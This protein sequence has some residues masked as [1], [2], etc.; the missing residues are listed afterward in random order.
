MEYRESNNNFYSGRN[1]GCAGIIHTVKSG[2]TLYR[3]SKMHNVALARI[4]EANPDIDI[5][6]LQIGSQICVPVE[7]PMMQHPMPP[8]PPRPMVPQPP[9]PM[10]PQAPSMN[11]NR[12]QNTDR[13]G[14]ANQYRQL[15]DNL[16][17]LYKN[18]N[19]E[20]YVC[21]ECPP[22]RECPTQRECPPQ[23]ECPT[24]PPQNECPTC[25][26]CGENI[27][28]IIP[29]FF[30]GEQEEKQEEYTCY[31]WENRKC[32]PDFNDYC[33]G[34]QGEYP[35]EAYMMPKNTWYDKYHQNMNH[36]GC[37]CCR[38]H[39]NY[40]AMLDYDYKEYQGSCYKNFF[41]EADCH[42]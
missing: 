8:E 7:G 32:T 24:C 6:N 13:S 26:Q 20:Q 36:S 4:M 28:V 41:K 40:N 3:I 38:N 11:M 22:Q 14:T 5:Y 42:K 27:D 10:P 37:N 35:A 2:D 9:R 12:Q 25:P 31:P 23:R 19:K 33:E 21:P 15:N 30:S 1:G 16:S 34:M 29:I 18:T 39:P 17:K